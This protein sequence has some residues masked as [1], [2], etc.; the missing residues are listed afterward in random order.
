MNNADVDRSKVRAYLEEHRSITDDEARRFIGTTRV[1]ARIWDLRH[2]DGLDI[3][4]FMISVPKREGRTARVAKYM[5]W[6]DVADLISPEGVIEALKSMKYKVVEENSSNKEFCRMVKENPDTHKL[7]C[8]TV[9]KDEYG[10][11][12]K[13]SLRK[14]VNQVLSDPAYAGNEGKLLTLFVRYTEEVR[15]EPEERIL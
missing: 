2:L 15:K 3:V 14:C 13:T 12:Y 6:T 5:F 11:T 9:P 10:L 1:G 7:F 4:T 8:V